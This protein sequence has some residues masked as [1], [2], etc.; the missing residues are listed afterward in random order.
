[1]YVVLAVFHIIPSV[2][3]NRYASRIASLMQTQRMTDVEEALIAQKTFWR[4]VGIMCIAMISL[5]FLGI[6]IV[7]VVAAMK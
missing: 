4:V 7:A 6:A 2:L 3:L 5:Y 1:M